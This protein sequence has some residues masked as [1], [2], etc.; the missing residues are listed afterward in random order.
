MFNKCNL[1]LLKVKPTIGD[2]KILSR[3]LSLI[4]LF[5]F[6]TNIVIANPENNDNSLPVSN[7]S[8]QADIYGDSTLETISYIYDLSFHD[9][10]GFGINAHIVR[11]GLRSGDQIAFAVSRDD[12]NSFVIGVSQVGANV[13]LSLI[14][15]S[16]PTRPY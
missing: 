10:G 12:I 14:H 2:H 13:P 3:I 7:L 5:F 11:S 16:E 15:I 4:I 9:Y 6:S 8:F 1:Y